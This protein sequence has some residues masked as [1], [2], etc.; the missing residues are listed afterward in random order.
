MPWY[1]RAKFLRSLS[2]CNCTRKLCIQAIHPIYAR[3]IANDFSRSQSF[4][5][6]I[7]LRS[8]IICIHDDVDS[9]GQM[10][11]L[12]MCSILYAFI[13]SLELIKVGFIVAQIF[14]W[15]KLNRT[16]RVLQI[17][18]CQLCERLPWVWNWDF[19]FK[20]LLL[21]KV[22]KNKSETPLFQFPCAKN[23]QRHYFMWKR[24]LGK[25]KD[26]ERR[27]KDVLQWEFFFYQFKHFRAPNMHR[28]RQMQ[29]NK[30]FNLL[31]VT[32]DAPRNCAFYCMLSLQRLCMMNVLWQIRFIW[33][34]R[35]P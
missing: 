22:N 13:N 15:T 2:I 29:P 18:V 12:P 19:A 31:S 6:T 33:L 28:Q 5:E 8:R 24:F 4:N 30:N 14:N 1:D 35:V 7:S 11:L 32:R 23:R 26:E 16:D 17:Q 21:Q 34:S 25:R 27:M 20:R 3:Y 10:Q 9:A